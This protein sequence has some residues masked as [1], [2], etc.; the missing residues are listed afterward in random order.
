MAAPSL[1]ASYVVPREDFILKKSVVMSQPSGILDRCQDSMRFVCFTCPLSLSAGSNHVE[2]ATKKDEELFTAHDSAH[3]FISKFIRRLRDQHHVQLIVST[4]AL[5]ESVVANCTR[6]DIACVQLA[7]PEDVEA[8]CIISGIFPLASVF[9]D[10][11][12]IMHVGVCTSGV[13]RVRFQQQACLRLRGVAAER[14]NQRDDFRQNEH[15]HQEMVV[16]QLLILAPTK[17]VY[18]QYYAAIVKSLRVLRSWWEPLEPASTNENGGQHSQ[19]PS[20]IYTCR[21]GGAT[22]LAVAQWL[23]GGSSKLSGN[24]LPRDGVM[25]ALARQ[26]LANA[27]IESVSTLRSCLNITCL[28]AGDVKPT[29]NQRQVLLEAFSSLKLQGRQ[30]FQGYT[31]NYSRVVQTLAGLSRSLSL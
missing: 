12:G 26:V 20:M 18:K 14:S 9:D 28:S 22:E 25:N 17:G 1:Y 31:L 29:G 7:E 6:Q 8:L 23:Q 13:S 5:D 2:L 30:I 4:E 11:Q 16:P 10:I 27:L 24:I 15:R 3:L 21:G 19:R